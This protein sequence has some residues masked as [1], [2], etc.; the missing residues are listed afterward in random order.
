MIRDVDPNCGRHIQAPPA[1][2]LTTTVCGTRS[3][4]PRS[5]CSWSGVTA[6][7][8]MNAARLAPST[9]SGANTLGVPWTRGIER[10][11]ERL[12]QRGHAARRGWPLVPRID[13]RAPGRDRFHTVP[14]QN[15]NGTRL[16]RVPTE[17][18][19]TARASSGGKR[20]RDRCVPA[21]DRRKARLGSMSSN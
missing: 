6:V 3:K 1:V 13:G 7:C 15:Q 18:A 9:R 21:A 5:N 10:S 4:R 17:T 11:F 14:D 2:V 20:F 8:S 12:P 16:E 19:V